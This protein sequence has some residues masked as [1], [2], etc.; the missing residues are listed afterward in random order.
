MSHVLHWKTTL[1]R[2]E[3]S[4]VCEKVEETDG[5]RGGGEGMDGVKKAAIMKKLGR[6]SLRMHV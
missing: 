2:E 6:E 4:R 1:T 5:V 3:D